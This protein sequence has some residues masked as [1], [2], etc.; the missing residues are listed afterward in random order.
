MK[1]MSRHSV[2]FSLSFLSVWSGDNEAMNREEAYALMVQHTPSAS[3]QRHML[4]VEQ[5]MRWY[6]RTGARMK[7]PTRWRGC[8]TTLTTSCTPGNTPPGA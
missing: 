3:L 8:Y 5:A 6:A 2:S 4:N 1:K 7:K